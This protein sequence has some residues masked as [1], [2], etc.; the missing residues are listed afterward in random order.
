M[1]F[2]SIPTS[3][4][5]DFD[6]Q[7]LVGEQ[8][9]NST[10]YLALDKQLNA[11]L[12]IKAIEKRKFT[13]PLDFYLEARRLYDSEHPHV[14]QIKYACQDTDNI[15]LAM[16]Y[17]QNGSLKGLINRN[18]LT[19][20]QIIRYALQFLSGL[21][22]IHVKGFIHFDIKP[23]NILLSN[24][25][26]ALVADFGI[27]KNMDG[28]GLS[29]IGCVYNA[30]IPPEAFTGTAQS[31]QYDIYGAGLTLYRLCNGN[32]RFHTQ[33]QPFRTQPAFDMLAFRDAVCASRFPAR[34]D[35]LPHIPGALRKAIN[36]AINVNTTDR[37]ASVLDLINQLSPIHQL[38]DW[39]FVQ[40]PDRC[41]WILDKAE[42]I[43]TVV[44]TW[45]GNNHKIETTKTTKSSNQTRKVQ[46]GCANQLA[47]KDVNK[48]IQDVLLAQEA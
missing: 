31:M 26:E 16:P 40:H 44:Y 22:N 29:P 18:F 11:Q 38:L 4:A 23:D 20:R 46:A 15:Y 6:L 35:Y 17:Y 30:H 48:K 8:G 41:E 43:I 19:V 25:D 9:K 1:L 3:A 5:L 24:T 47:V 34:N 39:H 32:S 21:H 33:L 12:V 42:S 45:A 37:H 14:V 27:S 28:Q 2:S 10:V 13:N 7:Q 36:K